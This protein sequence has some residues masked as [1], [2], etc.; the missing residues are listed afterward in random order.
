[1]QINPE[2]A[3]LLALKG[4]KIVLIKFIEKIG[5][6]HIIL[7]NEHLKRISSNSLEYLIENL[8][9]IIEN[10]EFIVLISSW[11]KKLF[12]SEFNLSHR[13]YENIIKTLNILI[14]NHKRYNLSTDQ[15]GDLKYII[16]TIDK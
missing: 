9:S 10:G 13:I 3:L 8:L 4:D 12:H 7:D 2:E 14:D 6:F 16:S 1:M 11:F 5:I 15:I